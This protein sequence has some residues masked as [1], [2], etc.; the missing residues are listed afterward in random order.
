METSLVELVYSGKSDVTLYL[1]GNWKRP[2]GAFVL[3]S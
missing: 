3:G 1:I 2:P